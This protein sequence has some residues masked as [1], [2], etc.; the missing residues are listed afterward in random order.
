M[1]GW[2]LDFFWVNSLFMTNVPTL[3]SG[4]SMFS[5]PYST[6]YTAFIVVGLLFGLFETTYILLTSIA[7]G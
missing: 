5:M 3:L 4:V 2:F 7:F 6:T 1:V